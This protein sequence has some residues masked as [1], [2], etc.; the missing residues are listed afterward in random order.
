MSVFALS[1]LPDVHSALDSHVHS[2]PTPL[3]LTWE[4][5]EPLGAPSLSVVDQQADQLAL[6][7]PLDAISAPA[8]LD[9]S[10]TSM[11]MTVKDQ[12]GMTSANQTQ[13]QRKGKMPAPV[14]TST[15]RRSNRNNKYDGFKVPQPSDAHRTKSKVKPR[16]IP[17]AAVGAS[18]PSSGDD[19]DAAAPPPTSIPTMQAIGMNLCAIPAEELSTSALNEE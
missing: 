12:G 1:A 8:L 15:L 7:V 14:D 3:L 17:S 5:S 16:I 6:S 13:K 10:S 19:D 2:A 18:M 11:A 9:T 4:P